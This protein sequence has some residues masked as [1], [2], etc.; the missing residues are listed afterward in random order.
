MIK[1]NKKQT[2]VIIGIIFIFV[3]IAVSNFLIK[4]IM[5]ETTSDYNAGV[6][7]KTPVEKFSSK[8]KNLT[9]KVIRKTRFLRGNG[10]IESLFYIDNQK[11]ACLREYVDGHH[12]LE[13]KIPDGKVVFYDLYRKTQGEEYYRNGK[14]NGTIK[15]YYDNKQIKSEEYYQKG[16]LVSQTKY[17]S[18][19]QIKFELDL[20]NKAL[21]P[22]DK[23][24]NGIG[25]MYHQNG[26]LKYEW[27]FTFGS[28]LN[29]RKS[30]DLQGRLYY[31]AFYD[32]NGELVEEKKY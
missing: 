31:A 20:K 19:G 4:K 5:N 7:K 11:I 21:T 22:W 1:I 13:G 27:H 28:V 12:E 10:Y 8:Y 18:T 17:F 23:R 15:T 14:K 26:K 29:Y 24:E 30:Y 25:K 6:E 3:V 9:G 16:R 2:A 32:N